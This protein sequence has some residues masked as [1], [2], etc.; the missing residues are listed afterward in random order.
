MGMGIRMWRV[1]RRG[2]HLLR[3]REL[4]P[5]SA[6]SSFIRITVPPS[7]PSPSSMMLL[8]LLLLLLRSSHTSLL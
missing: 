6:Q 3:C 4:L 1:L 8:L 7:S 5:P 2:T